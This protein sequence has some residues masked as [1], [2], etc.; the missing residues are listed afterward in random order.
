MHLK[1]D[2]KWHT[3]L[4][5]NQLPEN[6]FKREFDWMT[7]EDKLGASFIK[8]KGHFYAASEFELI[9]DVELKKNWDGMFATS[10]FS[11]VLIKI[12]P[13]NT[14]EYKIASIY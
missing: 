12:N 13:L 4:D 5:W 6:T 7:E 14:D 1:T 11:A 10:A 9:Q 2:N 3:F 8:Y